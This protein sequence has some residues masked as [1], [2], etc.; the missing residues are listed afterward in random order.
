[1]SPESR[2]RRR[3]RH[4]GTCLPSIK[5]SG[6][7]GASVA[8]WALAQ[9]GTLAASPE[10]DR[11]VGGPLYTE[12]VSPATTLWQWGLAYYPI[13]VLNLNLPSKILLVLNSLNVLQIKN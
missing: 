8:G 11:D 12:A 7:S 13:Y 3:G 9:G 10:E 6:C 5:K 2:G 1:M 4:A